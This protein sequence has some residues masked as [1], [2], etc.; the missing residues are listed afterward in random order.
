MSL[1]TFLVAS[2]LALPLSLQGAPGSVLAPSAEPAAKVDA[3]PSAEKSAAD[4]I[5]V[6]TAQAATRQQSLAE[7]KR[8]LAGAPQQIQNARRDL[9]RLKATPMAD[10]AKRYANQPAAELE[11]Y[12]AERV[13]ELAAWQKAL[14]EANSLVIAAQTR[15][16][17]AQADAGNSQ[18]RVLEIDAQLSSGREEGKPI[19]TERSNVLTAELA[20]LQATIELRRQELAGNSLLLDLGKAQRDL[21]VEQIARAEQETLALQAMISEQRREQSEQTV[22]ELSHNSDATA[23]NQILMKARAENLKLSNYLLQTTERL[24]NLT[25]QNLQARQ[26]LDSLNQA[27]RVLEEQIAVLDGSPLLSRI[28]YQ[29]QQALPKIQLNNNLADD[30]ADLR[31]Y[32]FELNQQ[33]EGISDPEAYADG[34]LAVKTTEAVTPELR[35]ALLELLQSRAELLKRLEPTLNS[36][37]NESITLQLH[38]RQM[39]DIAKAV[40]KTIDEQMFW[41]PSNKPLSLAWFE[42]FPEH[43]VGQMDSM[44]WAPVLQQWKAGLLERPLF[45]LPLVLLILVMLWKRQAINTRLESL[46][47]GIGHYSKDSQLHT[48]LALLLNLLLA[49]PGTLGLALCGYLLQMDG[50]GQNAGLGAAFYQVAQAWLVFYT[51]YLILL[52]KRMAE[53]HFHWSA[54]QVGFLRKEI[55]RLGMVVAVLVSVVAFATHQPASLSDDVA[56]F[57]VVLICYLLMAVGLIRLLFKGPASENAQPLRQTLGLLFSLLPL[58]LIL[59]VGLGYYYTALKLTGRLIDTLYLLM[60]WV[61]LEAILVRGLSVAARRLA[62]Q[63]MLAKRKAQT[64]ETTST[65]NSDAPEALEEPGR[66][67]EQVNQQSLRLTRMTLFGLFS[68]ALYWVWSDLI[69][70]V[71]YLDNFVLYEFGSGSGATSISLRDFLAALLMAGITLALARNLPGLLEVLVLSRLKLAQGSAYATSTLLSYALTGIGITVTLSALGVSWD[72][73]QWLV[74]ALSVGLGFGLQEIFANFVSGLIILFERPV[75]IGDVVTISNLSGRVT[76][77]R[78][79]ATTITD[80]DRKEIIVPNKTFITTQLVNWS[81]TDTVTRVTIKL[82]VAYGSDLELVRKL[83]RQAAL[84]NPRV[85][86]EPPPEVFFLNFGESTLDHELRIHVRELGDRTPVIDEINRRIE[87]EFS[88]NGISIAFRQVDILLKNSLNQSLLVSPSDSALAAPSTPS[89]ASLRKD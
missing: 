18:A 58:I 34:L 79:R 54:A 73:L 83:M 29:Q 15:P 12:L 4:Q 49:L 74:A 17:R 61:L 11:R 59:V 52:P 8:Q 16:E 62:Y 50:R 53:Q 63:R 35:T 38:Q 56:G 31:L 40:R 85:L 69:S 25:R 36:L 60:V 23:P 86:R 5:Q 3:S 24:N 28:L 65:P 88:Q 20:T 9:E 87:R 72:K 7:L 26:Q 33:R 44:P 78:I 22:A 1:R 77:I 2:L 14:S 30:I 71:S 51:T 6:L 42:S 19:S 80:F 64:E 32:Q 68:V 41:I 48:P 37:L 81:L 70:V 84:D 39:Q 76:R 13:E 55:R 82:G 89:V 67:I 43:L 10:P 27:D 66:N 45:F 57:V 75:R 21:L 46:N 47:R